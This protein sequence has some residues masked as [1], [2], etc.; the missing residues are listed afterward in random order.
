MTARRPRRPRS[1]PAGVWAAILVVSLAVPVYLSYALF[2][3]TFVASVPVTVTANRAGLVM[4]PGTKVR[5]RG[6][7]VGKV[8]SVTEQGAGPVTLQLQLDPS[9]VSAIPANVEAQIRASTLFGAKYIDLVYPTDPSV[10]H[11][12]A[13][14]V[15]HSRN[16][17]TEVNTVFQNLM[18][19]LNQI[20]PEKLSATLT[21]LADGVRGQGQ[22]IGHATTASNEVLLAVN[23]RMNTAAKDWRSLGAVAGAYANAAP[24]IVST[25][26]AASTTATTIVNQSSA[27]DALL[28]NVSGL[29]QSGINLLG[30]T[31]HALIDAVNRLQP[32]TDLL[33]KYNPVLTCTLMGAKWYVDNAP[34]AL[35]GNG[36]SA[37]IDAFFTW[38]ADPFRYP[39][40]LPLV[41]AKGG[42]GG[43]PSCGSLPDVTKNYPVRELVMN[44]GWGTG[45]DIRPNVGIASPCWLDLLP[46]TRA[47]PKPASVRRCLPGPAPGPA[48][49]PGAPP[50]GA[51]QHL[52]LPPLGQAP[53]P[54]PP[55]SFPGPRQ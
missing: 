24:A 27:L 45:L 3:G 53:G 21:A 9:Q 52:P 16:V 55:L 50:Y 19:V 15:L 6:V 32:T 30:P 51:P 14:A 28:L 40:N 35:G 33:L 4:N 8:S 5:L 23:P 18:N 38:G 17:S 13:G 47:V 31:E 12:G 44:T 7:E 49:A 25:L 42:P 29:A 1:I 46:V 37:V 22:L 26:S 41:A 48:S 2:D 10:R 34:P 36:K 11:I 20:D 43:K 54:Q 39:D